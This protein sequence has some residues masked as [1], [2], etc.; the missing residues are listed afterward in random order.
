MAT[1]GALALL[2][3]TTGACA[4]PAGKS[5][6]SGR[7]VLRLAVVGY[8]G[9]PAGQVAERFAR[10]VEAVSQGSMEIEVEYWPSRFASITRGSAVDAS[11]VQAVRSNAT[12]LGVV[13]T[14][15]FGASG[16]TT[17]DALQAPFVIS[18]YAHAVRA[19]A[20]PLAERLQ[21]GLP[22][23]G[24]TGLGLVP[25]GMYRPFGFLK[26]L[27]T[28]ADFA[29]TAVR[30]RSSKAISDVLRALGARP[31]EP[32]AED[33]DTTVLAGFAKDDESPTT[34]DDFFPRN[35]FAAGNVVLFP[36]VDA[37]VV[38][39]GALGRLT[40]GQQATLRRAAAETR[41]ET[42]AAT[43]EASAAA[44]YCRAGGTMVTAPASA[45]SGLRAKTSPLLAAMGRHAR[46]RA[47]I[48]AIERLGRGRD[49]AL[50]QCAPASVQTAGPE[51]DALTRESLRLVPP[52]GSYR[53]VFTIHDLRVAGAGTAEARAN[54]GVTTLTLEG[55]C[56]I[57][58]F[59]LAWQGQGARATCRGLAELI[60]GLV[61]LR[62]NPA[63]PCSG[64]VAFGWRLDGRDLTIERFDPLTRPGWL[65]RAYVGT[66]KRV[67][68]TPTTEGLSTHHRHFS[69]HGDRDRFCIRR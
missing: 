22:A 16:V 68:C 13:P 34:A 15:A 2:M 41:S 52:I 14:A 38:A 7:V 64:Y 63:T 51:L 5:G 57:P 12:Q 23:I 49:T 67:D 20:A 10:R 6:G 17:L 40:A 48:G 42:V 28:P 62:W 36:K 59:E 53:R 47:L 66:W 4:S 45:L 60:R 44:A 8:P 54:S 33:I 29:G 3:V 27:M 56:C 65:E 46:T 31:A 39:T 32:S 61:Q 19:T 24:L 18:S 1:A 30:A 58:R 9:K 55:P 21:A 11:A 69:H 35:A 26:A 50:A 37:I 43:D 25:E